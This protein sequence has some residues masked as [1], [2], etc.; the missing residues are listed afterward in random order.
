MFRK[1]PPLPVENKPSLDA[2]DAENDDYLLPISSF[3]YRNENE[4]KNLPSAPPVFPKNLADLQLEGE[5]SY[6]SVI[7]AEEAQLSPPS[8]PRDDT[9]SETYDD[10]GYVEPRQIRSI[11]LETSVNETERH[12]KLKRSKDSER[13]KP[14]RVSDDIAAQRVQ[15]TVQSTTECRSHTDGDV[16]KFRS[17]KSA[18]K[19]EKRFRSTLEIHL[20]PATQHRHIAV[21]ATMQL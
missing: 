10:R 8:L 18:G 7:S 19:K 13:Q 14:T 5:G 20:S 9:S 2:A 12:R 6:L 17:D 21:T 4:I 1:L 15:K 3:P 11:P 16:A